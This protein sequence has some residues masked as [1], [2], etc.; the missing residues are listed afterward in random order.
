MEGGL[1]S[2][3]KLEPSY[4]SPQVGAIY[5]LP[6]FSSP[7]QQVDVSAKLVELTGWY[8]VGVLISSAVF[9]RLSPSMQ[10]T[11]WRLRTY[12]CI[13]P[14]YTACTTQELP[15]LLD[16]VLLPN[17]AVPLRIYTIDVLPFPEARYVLPALELTHISLARP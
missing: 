14:S 16:R 5:L 7:R 9:D 13:I 17:Q 6:C 8:R 10:V 2:T 1:G 11:N 4:I 3:E 15:R 12:R